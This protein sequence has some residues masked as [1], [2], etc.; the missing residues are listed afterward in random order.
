MSRKNK[1]SRISWPALAIGVCLAVG[2]CS[3]G[4][5]AGPDASGGNGA[6]TAG[7][8]AAAG[9]PACASFGKAYKAFLAGATPTNQSGNSW[10]ELNNALGKITGPSM[11]SGGVRLDMFNLANDSLSA[12]D[13][14]SQG[15]DISGDVS[16]FNADLAKV[17]KA[18]G[19]ALTPATI[20]S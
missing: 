18:C 4:V 2:G 11:P 12:S 19:A 9:N 1:V 3:G 7:S 20:S 16:R 10:D 13:D 15:E 6:G 14:L 5:S 8:S 17:G